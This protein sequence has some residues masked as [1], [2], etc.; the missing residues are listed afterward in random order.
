MGLTEA[1]ARAAGHDVA[2]GLVTFDRVEK[3]ELTGETT[4]F[5][6]YVA[7][8]G[9]RRVLGCHVIGPHAAD[10]VYSATVVIR[11]RGTLDELA[12]AV[13]IFPTL[14]E[15]ME[16]TARGLLRRLAAAVADAPLATAPAA[17]HSR[18]EVRMTPAASF[19]CPACGAD[20]EVRDRLAQGEHPSERSEENVVTPVSSV[21]ARSPKQAARIALQCPACGAEFQT[22]ER[23]PPEPEREHDR[24]DTDRP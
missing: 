12:T 7:E 20:F 3:A 2:V 4:G 18:Q 1:A 16:G 24:I 5:I 22:E 17:A 6:K 15:G 11:R 23:L 8:R 19:T 14:A 9:S 10:L 13:G 21:E